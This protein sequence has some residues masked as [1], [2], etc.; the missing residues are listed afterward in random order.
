MVKALYEE[1]DRGYRISLFCGCGIDTRTGRIVEV[2]VTPGRTHDG[3]TP[4]MRDAMMERLLA[5]MGMLV[6]FHLQAG[7]SAESL[8]DRLNAIRAGGP[9][10]VT[11]PD[12]R[13]ADNALRVSSLLGAIVQACCVAQ[14]DWRTMTAQLAREDVVHHA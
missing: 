9:G 4:D 5:D 8:S 2:F 3:E 7:A 14:M 10:Y 11:F 13:G 12:A 1:P 6:S